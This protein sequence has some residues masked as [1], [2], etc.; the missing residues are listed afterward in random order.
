MEGKTS[1]PDWHGYVGAKAHPQ[2][3]LRVCRRSL[4]EKMTIKSYMHRGLLGQDTFGGPITYGDPD[5]KERHRG[6]DS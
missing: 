4:G 1:V 3:A 5:P 2:R 6:D